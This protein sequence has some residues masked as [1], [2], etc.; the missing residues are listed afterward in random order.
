MAENLRYIPAVN[1]ESDWSNSQPKYYVHS[2]YGTNMEAAKH[3]ANYINFGVLYNW[4]AAMNGASSS[5]ANPSGVQGICPNGW[6]KPSDAEWTEL[7]I[8]LKKH[9]YNF[10]EYVDTDNDRETHNVIAKSMAATSGWRNSDIDLTPGWEQSKNDSSKFN[11]KP[12]GWY[13][14]PNDGDY[15]DLMDAGGWWSTSENPEISGHKIDW[16]IHADRPYLNRTS[17]HNHN[18]CPVRCVQD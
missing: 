17:N 1:T 8:Y 11:G 12:S 9:G 15:I 10:D 14:Y 4:P 2:Y 13:D 7:E 6:H 16:Y 5:N 18:A 3:T